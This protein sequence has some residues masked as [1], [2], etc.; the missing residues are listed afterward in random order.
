MSL[1]E[2]SRPGCY[3]VVMRPSFV[4]CVLGLQRFFAIRQSGF[5][6]RVKLRLL[7]AAL[8]TGTFASLEQSPAASGVQVLRGHVPKITGL[9]APLGRLDRGYH[10][11]VAIGLPLRNRE[12][13]T[14]LLADIYNPSSPNFRHY[15]TADEF[16]KSFSPSVE[17]HDAVIAFAKSHNLT[18]THTH[19]NRTL[20]H[21]TGS[22]ADIESAF[23][24]HMQTYR[25]PKDGRTFFAPDVEPS[26]DLS[27]PVL[28]IS[29]LDNYSP[30]RTLIRPAVRPLGGGSGGGGGSGSGG[31]GSGGSYYGYDFLDA[32]LPG[33]GLGGDGQSVGLFELTGYSAQDISD[34]ED[35]TGLPG[36]PLVNVLVD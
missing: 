6:R 9:L 23:H 33:V 30:P 14:N 3:H 4:Q 24:I 22:V 18:V 28:A 7:L 19:P 2:S 34:Y 21:V 25:R 27:T 13:L 16:T 20:V 35:E 36:A 26:L 11:E 29:G 17:D 12:Q 31:S 8:C 32:Y 1:V 15:L 5:A 10:M